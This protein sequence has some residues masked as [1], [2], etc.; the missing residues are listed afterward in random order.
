VLVGIVASF[1]A[2]L[3]RLAARG[4]A[5]DS[6]QRET[7]KLR[8]DRERSWGLARALRQAEHLIKNEE[9]S[10]SSRGRSGLFSPA[11]S[12]SMTLV[13][14]FSASSKVW[15]PGDWVYGIEEAGYRA[16]R[17]WPTAGSPLTSREPSRR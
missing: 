12:M 5:D 16:G 14:Y 15:E 2:R 17:W 4:R 9:R 13:P 7:L 1:E 8:D 6:G 10:R 3:A 11:G